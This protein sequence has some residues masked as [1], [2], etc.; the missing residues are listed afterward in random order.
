MYIFR[1]GG[2]FWR[3]RR[4]PLSCS[5]WAMRH[6]WTD[7]SPQ[8]EKEFYDEYIVSF[9]IFRLC[10]IILLTY[11]YTQSLGLML[12]ATL[13]ERERMSGCD[14][15]AVLGENPNAADGG[16]CAR[17][18]QSFLYLCIL[19]IHTCFFYSLSFACGNSCKIQ[20][21]LPYRACGGCVDRGAHTTLNLIYFIYDVLT[22]IQNAFILTKFD[23]KSR[24][25]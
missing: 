3:F 19:I 22:Y 2:D 11:I 14:A 10:F 15:K 20:I 23:G 9:A 8:Q 7:E 21:Y 24:A 13:L 16:S 5:L 18:A 17:F 1:S 4:I 12:L 6:F 25:V